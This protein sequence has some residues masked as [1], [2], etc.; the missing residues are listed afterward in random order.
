[1]TTTTIERVLSKICLV[2]CFNI[3]IYGLLK[4]GRWALGLLGRC[5]QKFLHYVKLVGARTDP[6]VFFGGRGAFDE[7][8]ENWADFVKICLLWSKTIIFVKKL[9]NRKFHYMSIRL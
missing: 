7:K 1:M 8:Y 5:M 2:Y 4:L 6:G 3:E 9:I